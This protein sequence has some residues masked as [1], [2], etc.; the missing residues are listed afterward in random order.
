MILYMYIKEKLQNYSQ[1]KTKQSR[2]RYFMIFEVTLNEKLTVYLCSKKSLFFKT[3]LTFIHL[4]LSI[5]CC[6]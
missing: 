3:T 6:I 5:R 2:E 4:A 1:G